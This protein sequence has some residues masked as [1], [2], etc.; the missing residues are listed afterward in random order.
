MEKMRFPSRLK[1]YLPLIVLFALLVFL[2]PKAPKFSYDY[3][4]GSP[5]MYE[6][7]IAQFDFPI[8]KTQSQIQQEMEKAWLS[9]I[10]YY[11]LNRSVSVQAEKNLFSADLG[12]YSSSKAELAAALNLIYDKGVISQQSLSDI[13]VQNLYRARS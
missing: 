2:M 9:V 11:K 13:K 8:L 1:V 10:P 3:Q 12:K 7:L 6:T 4:K 5:W